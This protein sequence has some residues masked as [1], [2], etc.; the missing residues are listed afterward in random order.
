MSFFQ[1]QTKVV[2]IDAEN[3]VT[4]RRLT[5]GEQQAV[6]SDSTSFDIVSQEAKF[7]FA[8]NQAA[9]L[10]RAVV[11]WEGAGF[12][13]RPVT[14]ENILALSPEVGQKILQAVEELNAGLS[15]PE[16]KN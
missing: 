10:S 6:I 14:A 8:K 13:G 12:D 7:D 11:S 2:H 9:K 4:V 16:Q 1:Q 3:T 5:F 15:E